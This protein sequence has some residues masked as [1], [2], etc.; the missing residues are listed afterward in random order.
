MCLD[1]IGIENLLNHGVAV[2]VVWAG[3]LLKVSEGKRHLI[4]SCGL[5]LK[6]LALKWAKKY[7]RFING[8]PWR[9][10]ALSISGAKRSRGSGRGSEHGVLGRAELHKRD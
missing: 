10:E 7:I 4:R 9:R 2:D 5:A 3:E 6:A 1:A 8:E